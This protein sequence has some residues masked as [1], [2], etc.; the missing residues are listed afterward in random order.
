M[1]RIKVIL[2][3]T[4]LI[5]FPSTTLLA[6]VTGKLAG[7]VKDKVTKEPLP[8]VNIVLSGTSMGA[9]TDFD[10]IYFIIGVPPGK[11]SIEVQMM[12]YNN[13][14][15]K[16]V[17]VM[18]DLTTTINFE[19]E[20][21]VLESK[22]E[23][24]VTAERPLIQPDITAKMSSIHSEELK[25]IP[26]ENITEVLSIMPGFTDAGH[27]RGGRGNEVAYMVDGMYLSDPLT[28]TF[29]ELMFD[30]D[31]VQ[32]MVV[33]SGTFNAEYGQAM[34]GI[35]NIITKDP[36]PQFVGKIEYMSP[37]LNTSP[38]RSYHE[39]NGIKM[40][41]GTNV[42][43]SPPPGLEYQSS[44]LNDRA[45]T[46]G[47]EN[48][49]G[50]L[51]GNLSGTVPF[52]HNL[53]F[54]LSGRYL[55][56]DSYLP[57]GFTLEREGMGK[58]LYRFSPALRLTYMIKSTNHTYQSYSHSFKYRPENYSIF[59][60]SSILHTLTFSHTISD[61]TFY[62]IYASF[63]NQTYDRKVEGN[64]VDI[65][66]LLAVESGD[67]TV[68]AQ[69]DYE[70]PVSWAGEF[71]YLGDDIYY[72]D[73]STT[74]Q[75]IK[76]ELTS[77]I[78]S[79]NLI[80][81]GGEAVQHTVDRLYF[82]Q[83]W[84]DGNHEY[85]DY[86]R[87]PI[88]LFA[89][90]QDKLEFDFLIINLGFRLDYFDPKATM[91]PNVYDPG[92]VDENNE[93]QYYPEENVSPQWQISPR[94]GLAHPVTDRLVFHFAY[95]HF[96]QRPDYQDMYYLHDIIKLFNVVGNPKMKPQKTQSF[97]FGVRNQIGDLFALDFDI[98][99]KD[100]FDLA[101]SSFQ[102]YYPHPY[103][104][105]DNSDYANAKGFEITIKKRYSHYFSGNLNYTWLQAQGN[106]NSADE[107]S[108]RYWGST[109]NRL[110]PRRPFP[111]DWD[112]RH[113]FNLVIDFRL[114]QGAG[115]AVLGI[116]PFS[117]FGAN[118]ITQVKSG[119]PYTPE[120]V[121]Y[122]EL[123]R[124]L[125]RNSARMPWTFRVDMRL[126]KNINMGRYSLVIFLKVLNLF[127][128]QNV[129]S[130][131]P[132]TG[133]PWDAGPTSNLSQDFQRYPTAYEPP[134]HIYFGLGFNW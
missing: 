101:G 123:E 96:F 13:V 7:S 67:T 14:M 41:D 79:H 117:D 71:I 115:P 124:T 27:L 70:R 107:G 16:N 20:S 11:Y 15:V 34:S 10:G 59:E 9:S 110:R 80:K 108:V 60:R 87:K 99:Y 93:F 17:S 12:G 28:N 129:Q 133:D 106:E 37:T 43:D 61:R 18:S 2:F 94:V 118:F 5:V 46:W 127:D 33:M 52:L 49:L 29:G 84:V 31:I 125:I 24:V 114:P 68:T 98:Y 32:E 109:N 76:L 132:L 134:R 6:G 53:T 3:S 82:Q 30:K 85:Q 64:D 45:G 57:S 88:E 92:Y 44:S 50:Q 73:E 48:F 83:P 128:R 131:Y 65:A 91:F 22:E 4:L 112:R 104:F 86:R 111:L 35:V 69:T 75:S 77:Q 58:L 105:Y 103:A 21:T 95:G 54:Y 120:D 62:S 102:L 25:T 122:P 81:A 26:V 90:I 89:Y 19:L 1:N 39:V 36:D 56:E 72:Q 42:E 63:Y 51:R 40:N 66:S 55:N 23:I 116:K 74:T 130:V 126:D 97:E 121:A 119:L 100:I 47:E 113:T 78:N 38:Y 8:G